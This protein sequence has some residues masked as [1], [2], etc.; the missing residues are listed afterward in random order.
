MEGEERGIEGRHGRN[1]KGLINLFW[2][3][4]EMGRGMVQ[5]NL[6]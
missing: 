3:C 1:G 6:D 4:F 2:M 5:G